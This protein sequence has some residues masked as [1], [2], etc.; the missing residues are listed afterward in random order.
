ML[1]WV[2]KLKVI[3]GGTTVPDVRSIT[4]TGGTLTNNGGG[5][6]TYDPPEFIPDPTTAAGYDAE[7]KTGSQQVAGAALAQHSSGSGFVLARADAIGTRCVGLLLQD[8]SSAVAGPVQTS[9]VVTVADWTAATGSASLSVH[10]RYFLDA[11]TPGKLTLVP[12][13]TVGQFVQAVGEAVGPQSLDV[14]IVD[15]ILL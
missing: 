4:F 7:N 2:R 1:E 11:A 5:S 15:P 12:P 3:L 8:T 13:S 6:V 10:G 14:N 9:G